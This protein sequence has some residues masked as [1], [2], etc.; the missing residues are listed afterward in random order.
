MKSLNLC[1]TKSRSEVV[2]GLYL[3]CELS[4]YFV[5]L[6]SRCKVSEIL[7]GLCPK[8]GSED[9]GSFGGVRSL[10]SLRVSPKV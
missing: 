4:E 3:G 5:G 1:D 6:S 10:I 7:D 2:V 8:C 9:L